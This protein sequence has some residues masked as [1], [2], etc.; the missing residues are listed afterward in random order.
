[1]RQLGELQKSADRLRD[2]ADVYIINPDTP[3][4]SRRLK[5]TTKISFP[6]LLDSDLA[7]ARQFD[8]LPKLGQPMGGMRGVPQMGF[9]I[10]DAGGTIRVQ[11]VDLN[12]GQHADQIVEILGRVS[13]NP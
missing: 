11:R 5:Q 8:M 4:A 7:V 9:V 3:D 13:E 2:R 6:V 12:F 10:I 1:M